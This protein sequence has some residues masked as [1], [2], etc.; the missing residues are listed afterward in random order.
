MKEL[1][2]L[3]ENTAG[4]APTARAFYFNKNKKLYNKRGHNYEQSSQRERWEPQART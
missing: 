4:E 2:F 3:I 1:L